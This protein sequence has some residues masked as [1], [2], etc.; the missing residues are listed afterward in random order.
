MVYGC[1][2][3]EPPAADSEAWNPILGRTRIQPD[4]YH[5]F[6]LAHDVAVGSIRLD[7]LPDG[8]ISRVRVMGNL[9]PSARRRAGYRW[10]NSLPE[11]QAVGS[12]VALGLP[13]EPAAQLVRLR[14]LTE[15]WLDDQHGDAKASAVQGLTPS[16]LRQLSAL[17]EG[18]EAG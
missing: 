15:T 2:S 3:E 6:P 7:A 11:G 17:L 10:F 5:V 16:Q 1:G 8:G 4:T 12:L 18:A 9:E 14:P 13:A